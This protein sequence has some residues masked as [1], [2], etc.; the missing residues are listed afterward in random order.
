MEFVIGKLDGIDQ[1]GNLGIG[2]SIV[3]NR[4]YSDRTANCGP[5]PFASRWGRAVNLR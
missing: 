1:L 2:R 5:D 3:L 4:F